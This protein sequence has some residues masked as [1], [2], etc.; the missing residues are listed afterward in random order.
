M[1]SEVPVMKGSVLIMGA[2]SLQQ[3]VYSTDCQFV[4]LSLSQNYQRFFLKLVRTQLDSCLLFPGYIHADTGT[5][6]YISL[7]LSIPSHAPGPDD[8][9][10]Y[11]RSRIDIGRQTSLP[12]C[13]HIITQAAEIAANALLSQS[14]LSCL[15]FCSKPTG[16][17]IN[18]MMSAVSLLQTSVV[19]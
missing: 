18:P 17:F 12:L 6:A 14:G 10:S 2:L 1:Y 13:N 19:W 9:E 5:I 11:W 15:R 3:V 7:V 8:I 16:P 4:V